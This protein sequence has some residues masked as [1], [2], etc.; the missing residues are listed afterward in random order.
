VNKLQGRWPAV[1]DRDVRIQL[2]GGFSVHALLTGLLTKA[3]SAGLTAKVAA[4]AAAVLVA[5]GGM[6]ATAQ[7]LE[8]TAAETTAETAADPAATEPTEPGPETG[9]TDSTSPETPEVEPG[10]DGPVP[11]EETPT[12]ET[13]TAPEPVD[14]PVATPVPDESPAPDTTPAPGTAPVA[15]PAPVAEASPEKSHPENHGA[16][17]SEVA[18]QPFESGREHGKAVSSAARDKGTGSEPVTT[19]PEAGTETPVE[20][21]SPAGTEQRGKHGKG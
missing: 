14:A 8:P 3:T 4:G 11:V 20:G 1:D 15:E 16:R 21:S 2:R 9:P 12:S 5:G 6:A 18:H 10:V 17:V 7:A 13:G 19:S